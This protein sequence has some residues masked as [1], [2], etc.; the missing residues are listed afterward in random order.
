MKFP[1]LSSF[2]YW[3]WEFFLKILGQIYSRDDIGSA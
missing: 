1:T 2:R 3:S